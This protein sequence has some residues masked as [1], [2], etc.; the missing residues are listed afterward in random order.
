MRIGIFSDRSVSPNLDGY[1]QQA[2]DAENDGFD[3]FWFA[4]VRGHGP[5][6]LTVIALAGQKTRRIRL[7]TAV[8]PTYPRHPVVMAQQ[9]LTTQAAT[10]GRFILGIGVSDPPMIEDF[11]GLSLHR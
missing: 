7:G 2:V 5:D 4:Q 3:S 9:G 1:I 8:L 11:L 6:V 10:G